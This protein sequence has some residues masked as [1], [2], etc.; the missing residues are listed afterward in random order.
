MEKPSGFPKHTL[1]TIARLSV[2]V[3][4]LVKNK[5]ALGVNRGA[6]GILISTKPNLGEKRFDGIV[7]W[8]SSGLTGSIPL[9]LLEV[10][11]ES[12]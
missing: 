8:C 1:K 12:R 4:D 7:R 2:K 11:S 6:M 10:I 3:G 9:F 5:S